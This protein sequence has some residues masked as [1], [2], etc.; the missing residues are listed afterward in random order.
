MFTEPPFLRGKI[1]YTGPIIRPLRYT[2]ADRQ[3]AR[4]E[5]GLSLDVRYIVSSRD[6]SRRHKTNASI[7]RCGIRLLDQAVEAS[8]LGGDA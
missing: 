7:D 6:T 4:Q 5:L 3:R 8:N 1:K 2:K